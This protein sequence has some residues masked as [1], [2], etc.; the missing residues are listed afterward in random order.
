MVEE[1][2]RRAERE[3]TWDPGHGHS[4]PRR[5]RAESSS[6]PE[7]E[8]TIRSQPASIAW[9]AWN[10]SRGERPG[11]DM[12][13]FAA[14]I[15]PR[16]VGCSSSGRAST[17][18]Q[19]AARRRRDASHRLARLGTVGRQGIALAIVAQP[20]EDE[21]VG[22]LVEDQTAD[23]AP[24]VLHL[25]QRSCPPRLDRPQGRPA[26]CP[27]VRVEEVRVEVAAAQGDRRARSSPGSVCSD[28]PPASTSSSSPAS[29]PLR[30][31]RSSP[32]RSPGRLRGPKGSPAP[33]R[34]RAT[35]ARSC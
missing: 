27:Q 17:A 21:P 35:G 32:R 30:C 10:A 26:L 6:K 13:D 23:D 24:A 15:T 4:G 22:E 8:L 20:G 5:S 11:C 2:P 33:R 3:P 19:V 16:S 14:S 7:S 31:P 34:G 18:R 12:S 25:T 1:E 28:Q 29:L 9:A